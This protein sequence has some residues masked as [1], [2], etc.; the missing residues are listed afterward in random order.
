ML[1]WWIDD[2]HVLVARM[3][4]VVVNIFGLLEFLWMA[5]D[6]MRSVRFQMVRSLVLPNILRVIALRK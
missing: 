5:V 1:R 6:D 2:A 3:S 4:D